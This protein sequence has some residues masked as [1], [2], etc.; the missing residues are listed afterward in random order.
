[1]ISLPAAADCH[2]VKQAPWK[3]ETD[4]VTA[5]F[6]LTPKGGADIIEGIDLLADGKSVIK[7]RVIAAAENNQ[8]N[9]AL[10]ILVAKFLRVPKKNISICSGETSRIKKLFMACSPSLLANALSELEQ[11]D[12]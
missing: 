2:L 10:I 9:V 3:A 6:R 11:R 12:G 5:W 1:M 4:G 8:A 7:A